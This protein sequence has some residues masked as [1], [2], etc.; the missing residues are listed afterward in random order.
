MKH[1]KIPMIDIIDCDL[2]TS[3][4]FGKYWH[5]HADNMNAIDKNTLKAVGQT[6]LDV[7]SA[8]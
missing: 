8:Y 4:H 2:N 6:L 3:S 1:L 5:T 7:I